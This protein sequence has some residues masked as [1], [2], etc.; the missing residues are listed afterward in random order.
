MRL[1]AAAASAG[2]ASHFLVHGVDAAGGLGGA[3]LAGAS[4][5]PRRSGFDLARHNSQ[6]GGHLARTV[7]VHL[8][9]VPRPGADA[10]LFYSL[11]T[12]GSPG[13]STSCR[14][15]SVLAGCQ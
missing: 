4:S 15:I 1:T 9:A 10:N 8:R 11:E 2:G 13:L 5:S 3:A 12:G 7:L 6:R 14:G